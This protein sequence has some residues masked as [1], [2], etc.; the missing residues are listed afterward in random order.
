[1]VLGRD[2]VEQIVAGARSDV[3]GEG[4]DDL[5]VSDALTSWFIKVRFRFLAN[6][7]PRYFILP[8]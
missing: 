1:M 8:L 2:L 7:P 6:V 3:A 5:T 4:A